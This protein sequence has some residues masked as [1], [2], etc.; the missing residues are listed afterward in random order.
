M[1]EK[2]N[3]FSDEFKAKIINVNLL[4]ANAT[5]RSNTL[6]QFIFTFLVGNVILLGYHDKK[7]KQYLLW[8]IN[9]LPT[10]YYMP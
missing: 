4:S 6:K 5:K 1:H 10:K 7:A 8:Q 3:Q 9:E 2:I